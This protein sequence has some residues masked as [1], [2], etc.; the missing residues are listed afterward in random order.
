MAARHATERS[1]L[2]AA[3]ASEISLQ[4]KSYA[5]AQKV[6]LQIH[7]E[8]DLPAGEVYLRTGIYDLESSNSGTREVPLSM[9][10]SS[11]VMLK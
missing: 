8:I 7:K 6:G 11:T 10:T 9:F 3:E 2:L 1:D 4:P 5:D